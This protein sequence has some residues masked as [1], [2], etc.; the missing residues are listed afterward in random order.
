MEKAQEVI[1]DQYVRLHDLRLQ[2]DSV[3]EGIR[4]LNEHIKEYDVRLDGLQSGTQKFLAEVKAEDERR[5]AILN[6]AFEILHNKIMTDVNTKI[7]S[8]PKA[9]PSTSFPSPYPSLQQQQQLPPTRPPQQ[10][11]DIHAKSIQDA[12]ASLNTVTGRIRDL[13]SQVNPN[14][15]PKPYIDAMNA[16]LAQAQME[17]IGLRNDHNS[18]GTLFGQFRQSQALLN[19]NT[20]NNF[21]ETAMHMDSVKRRFGEHRQQLDTLITAYESSQDQMDNLIGQHTQLREMFQNR[22]VPMLTRIVKQ[23]PEI[24]EDNPVNAGQNQRADSTALVDR[25]MSYQAPAAARTHETAASPHPP[26]MPN[27]DQSTSG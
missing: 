1:N 16:R 8:S 2:L 27:R 22:V 9:P 26:T 17:I 24:L 14:L 7:V 5:N 11:L 21:R 12:V 3:L 23:F 18:L 20:E 4:V 25:S 13:E 15:V 19:Q 6:D 10:I